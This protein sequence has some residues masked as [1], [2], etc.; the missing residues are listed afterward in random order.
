MSEDAW[1]KHMLPLIEEFEVM[2]KRHDLPKL[3]ADEALCELPETGDR[4]NQWKREY[5]TGF[6]VRWEKADTVYH[7]ER[8]AVEN[9]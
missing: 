5:L 6:I 2:I 7:L 4:Y 9:V 3:S 8:K 1:D